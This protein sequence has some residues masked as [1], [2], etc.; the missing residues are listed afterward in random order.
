MKNLIA[1]ALFSLFAFSCNKQDYSTINDTITKADSLF[2]KANDGLK[3][4]DSISKKVNDSNGYARK[5][6]VPTIEKQA[7]KIDS[8]L[9]SGQ[10]QIDSINK[11]MEKITK[12]VK[13]GTEMAKTLDSAAKLLEKGENAISVL[14]KTADKILERTDNQQTRI[15]KEKA[16]ENNPSTHYSPVIKSGI[17]EIE[18][19]DPKQS[20]LRFNEISQRNSA[21]ITHENFNKTEGISQEKI[22]VRL[23]L[24]NFDAMMN[25]LSASL[26]ELRLKSITQSGTDYS[27]DLLSGIEV[28]L[29]SKNQLSTPASNAIAQDSFNEK[30]SS[31]FK[32]GL[33]ILVLIFLEVL[34]YWPL[35][36]LIIVVIYLV[37]RNTKNKRKQIISPPTNPI[38]E[39]HQPIE[40]ENEQPS[41][42]EENKEP[43]YTKYMPK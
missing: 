1:I 23:P 5:I 39:T 10:W 2:T 34:P 3:T 4:L 16:R 14:T 20:K 40:N 19:E 13:T 11:E 8:T 31:A 41:N 33:H 17:L 43:D 29:I 42:I 22:K 26:G 36:L 27:T 25:E 21:Q 35:F 15:P 37:Q 24:Q 9:K 12:Q 38:V 18:V 6:L 32:K 30:S 7:Q 28:L